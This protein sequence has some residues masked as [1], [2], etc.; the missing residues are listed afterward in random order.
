MSGQFASSIQE[1]GFGENEVKSEEYLR[2]CSNPK[3]EVCL[4]LGKWLRDGRMDKPASIGIVLFDGN[5]VY[6]DL[7]SLCSIR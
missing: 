5:V 1:Y 2:I 7:L 3:A 6:W 4:I